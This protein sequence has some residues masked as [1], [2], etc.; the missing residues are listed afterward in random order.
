MG[1]HKRGGSEHGHMLHRV[2]HLA[3][4]IKIP[5]N[6]TE[7]SS[8]FSK[9]DKVG[10][11]V[12]SFNLGMLPSLG[13]IGSPRAACISSCGISIL[14]TTQAQRQRVQRKPKSSYLRRPCLSLLS[15][16]ALR[17]IECN[18]YLITIYIIYGIC[19]HIL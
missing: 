12:V 13:C 4:S 9:E 14:G 16:N 7:H 5:L 18:R 19:V 10:L 3:K 15:R 1:L 11:L 2:E 17:Q 6:P 8:V